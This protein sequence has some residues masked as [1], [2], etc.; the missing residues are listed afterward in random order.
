MNTIN[1]LLLGGAAILAAAFSSCSDGKENLTP[2][3]AYK[4][5]FAVEDSDNSPEAQIRREFFNNSGVYLLFNDTLA[6]YTDEYGRPKT[7][8]VDFD[9]NLT[10]DLETGASWSFLTTVEDKRKA[11]EIVQ[12][13]F[14]PYVSGKGCPFKPFSILLVTDLTKPDRYDDP[15]DIAYLSCWRCFAINVTDWLE[16][17]ASE[18]KTL[19]REL[20][21]ELV[22]GS[23][24]TLD[25]NL[26]DFYAISDDY[27]DER[28]YRQFPDWLDDQDPELVYDLG[29]LSYDKDSWDEADYDYFW[30]DQ[31]DAKEYLRCVIVGDEA[32]FI[33]KWADYPKIM[34]KYY[35][36]KECVMNLGINFDNQAE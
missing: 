8:T 26:S 15:V 1:K 14:L 20:L 7:E 36:M 10:D 22:N 17:D 5:Y 9:W 16:A 28:I 6:V 12:K 34:Q 32:E 30:D 13:Y 23:F 35:I 18:M 27:Y 3:P 31:H 24:S 19:T 11:S 21:Y 33:G 2:G 4:N 29:F 25:K